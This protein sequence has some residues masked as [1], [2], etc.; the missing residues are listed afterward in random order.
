MMLYLLA[1]TGVLAFFLAEAGAVPQT[2]PL[3]H[4]PVAHRAVHT[5]DRRAA[6]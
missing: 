3:D 6:E 4:C 5:A 2:N 1:P